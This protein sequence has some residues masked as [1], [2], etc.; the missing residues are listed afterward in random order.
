MG[1]EIVDKSVDEDL[2]VFGVLP[3]FDLDGFDVGG[4]INFQERKL[5]LRTG[6]EW[7]AKMSTWLERISL[8]MHFYTLAG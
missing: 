1:R 5:S 7:G 6:R 4:E 2:L 3:Q 8:K